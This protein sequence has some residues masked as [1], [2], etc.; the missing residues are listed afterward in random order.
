MVFMFFF[1]SLGM[2]IDVVASICT[3]DMMMN[4][5]VASKRG[6][7]SKKHMMHEIT[8]HQPFFE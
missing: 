1:F 5:C 8:M 2:V 7:P 3:K 4:E 6:F